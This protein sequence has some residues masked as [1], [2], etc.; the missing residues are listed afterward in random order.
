MSKAHLK[1]F[2]AQSGALSTG[3]EEFSDGEQKLDVVTSS[4]PSVDH[5]VAEMVESKIEQDE[6][7]R[8]TDTLVEAQESLEAYMDLLSEGMENGGI[9]AQ[10]AAFM[11]LGMERFEEMFGLEQPLT[12]SVE[13]FGGS[14]SQMHSTT[15]SL[16]ALSDTLK[17]G[18]EALKRALNALIKAVQ[19][20]YA[21]A[22]KASAKLEDRASKIR[23]AASGLAGKKPS[24]DTIEIKGAKRLFADGEW[25]GEN[26]DL[27]RGLMEMMSKKYPEAVLRYVN[28]V[29]NAVS[30]FDP[31]A[32]NADAQI[33]TI[34]DLDGVFNQF[35]GSNIPSNDTRF[36]GKVD[37]KRTKIMPGNQ[38]LYIARPNLTEKGDLE[39]LKSLNG[40]LIV[41][42]ME[43]PDAKK[44]PESY[45]L[46]VGKP[47]DLVQSASKIAS[48]A[49]L[50]GKMGKDREKIDK[51]I[52][53]LLKAGDALKE[54]ADKAELNEE[55][56]KTV[57][58]MLRGLVAVQKLLGTG[59]NGAVSYGVSTLNAQL[60]V[61]ERQIAAYGESKSDDDG[62]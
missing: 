39:G 3:M 14:A 37:A 38:A 6:I 29:A 62:E 21:K 28:D 44:A 10:S 56:K 7:S 30:K 5:E 17:K 55:Q 46:K 53:E 11:R 50:I 59:L 42:L 43:A 2:L 19:D 27:V 9:S 52:D 49:A 58:A 34:L 35:P 1:E 60:T 31:T 54:K 61:V 26:V 32:E 47:L 57:N 4:E 48:C 45:E 20:V 8:D 18:W 13:A 40:K 33:Q 12:P 51:A 22:T 25:V 15:V 16:E 24:S 23:S 36:G 41:A